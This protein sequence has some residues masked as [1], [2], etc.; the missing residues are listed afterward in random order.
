MSESA[1]I[2]VAG[3]IAAA[4]VLGILFLVTSCVVESGKIDE[5]MMT[6]CAESGGS[7]IGGRTP[8]CI[9]ARQ[10]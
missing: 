3:S 9:G 7:W 8:A 1:G 5:A 6:S 4:I 10:P 2:A